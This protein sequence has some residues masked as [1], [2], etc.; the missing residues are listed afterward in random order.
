[1]KIIIIGGSIGG[2]CAAIALADEGFEVEIYE[3]S[4]GDMKD[5]GAGLVIQPDMMEYL[6][7]RGI[8]PKAVFGVPAT[9]RQVLDSNGHAVLTYPNDTIFTSWNYIWKQLKNFFPSSKYFSGYELDSVEEEQGKVTAIFKNGEV[10]TADLIIGADGFNSVVRNHIAPNIHPKYA[11]YVAYRGL[12]AEQD[13]TKEEVDFFADKFSIYPYAGSHLLCYL[14]PGPNGELNKG[15][16]LY[17]WVWYQNK[18]PLEL[19][20]LLTDKNGQ[21]REYTVPAGYLSSKNRQELNTLAD[22]ELPAILS[23][24]VRQTINPFV[25]VM[26]DM[27]TPQMYKGR[28]VI[29][30]D[31]AS[32]VRP[33]TAS[34]TAKAYRDAITL[35]MS[36][37]ENEDLETALQ[38][39]NEHQTRHATALDIHGKQLAAQSGLG[40]K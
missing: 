36:L 14:V 5:R 37:Q 39:W 34:G 11:G 32:L 38:K 9:Q 20:E 28:V 16:R 27:K 22:H 19:A 1:M 26:L 24:R 29:L 17:N 23:N 10:K 3:R 2:L 33:H 6:M 18:T 21:K 13:L 7:E 4:L 12:I 31:A 30:G 15:N 35:A 25:Q 8:A 40:F